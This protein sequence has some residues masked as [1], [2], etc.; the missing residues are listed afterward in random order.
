MD[1]SL[2]ELVRPFLIGSGRSPIVLSVSGGV[3]SMVL[4][5]VLLDLDAPIVV[6]HVNHQLRDESEEE[7]QAIQTLCEQKTIPFEGTHFQKQTGN[8][9]AEARSFR[10]NFLKDVAHRYDA[11]TIM[12]AHHRDDRI[13]TF[14]M[15]LGEGR[16]LSGLNPMQKVTR[17]EGF[18]LVKPFLDVSK[19]SLQTYAES[20]GIHH[21]EDASNRDIHYTR[22]HVRHEIIPRFRSINPSFNEGIIQLMDELSDADRFLEKAVVNHESFHKD[23]VLVNEFLGF[24]PLFQRRFL[25]RKIQMHVPTYFPSKKELDDLIRALD[26]S[27]NFTRSLQD[28][29][30]LHKEYQVFFIGKTNV[31]VSLFMK[32]IGPGTYYT[33]K[34]SSIEITHEKISRNLTK[35]HELWYNDEVYPLY[36]RY[37]EDG[38][39][40]RFSYG[41]KKIKDLFIDLKIPPHKRNEIILLTDHENNVIWIPE[42]D[43]KAKQEPA[44]KRL[45]LYYHDVIT[46]SK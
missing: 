18:K 34:G 24:S 20:H 5:H 39:R 46:D 17:S 22:N 1:V 3:D 26:Q 7:Y 44:Q 42:L 23:T 27:G 11:S 41:H 30:T 14:I 38:D 43:L 10:L 29:V 2:Q 15:R 31:E 6:A 40:I 45:F 21:Y 25:K 19:E 32:I 37:R 13:E 4:L 28:G 33:P 12:T 16:T 9:Q 35:A 8:F 36:L